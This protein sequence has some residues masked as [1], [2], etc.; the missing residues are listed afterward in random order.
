MPR[1]RL[2]YP[3][4]AIVGQERVKRA[5]I[6]NAVDPTI[7]GVLIS[8]PKGSGKST[9]VR[10]FSQLL[11][12]VEVVANCPFRCNPHDPTNMCPSCLKRFES[13]EPLPVAKTTMEIVEMPLSVTD[14]ML[15]GT[16]DLDRIGEGVK[17][18]QP[19]LLAEANQNI[20]YIDQV[21]LLPD[22]IVD[23]ILDA[24]AS[25]WNIVER[26]GVSIQHP[27]RFILV[28][29]MNP[30]EGEL[31]PQ[32]L[33]RFG[34]YV[35]MERIEDPEIRLL[36]L[37]RSEEYASNPMR[38]ISKFSGEVEEL[39]R[40]IREARRLLPRVEI[41]KD[42][43]STI[44][45]VCSSLKVDG[46]RPDI[47]AVKAA[48]AL[49]A[50]HGR[51]VVS[52]GD[53]SQALE[54]ALGHRTRRS[55]LQPPPTKAEITRSLRRARLKLRLGLKTS[56]VG[57]IILIPQLLKRLLKPYLLGYLSSLFLIILLT[58]SLTYLIENFRRSLMASPPTLPL[59]ILE[60]LTGLTL[61][62]LLMG[63]RRREERVAIA[64]MID[65]SKV[66]LEVGGRLTP[67]D[68]VGVGGGRRA[69]PSRVRYRKPEE[70][71]ADYGF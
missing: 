9:L 35:E 23:C 47:V 41:P 12:E 37:K 28:G 22:H 58:A 52:E 53:V 36:V 34:I 45:E 20:L 16:L 63:M 42:V 48:R 10:A 46:F 30:E 51:V 55:G 24:A 19:G 8:G 1:G 67:P 18:L 31:R 17:A 49:A 56:K 40:R 44:A 21:N 39:K 15:V 25:G 50:L 61:T 69:P 71:D 4:P 6:I 5:L 59:L 27:A 66:A 14:D 60:T 57:G 3:F 62:L 26:E 38:F 64:P 54:L 43:Y 2:L 32:I 33:D 29:T 68:R 11:P 65:L 13:G 7:G 70:P